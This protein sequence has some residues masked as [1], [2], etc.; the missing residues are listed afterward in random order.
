MRSSRCMLISTISQMSFIMYRPSSFVN[1]RKHYN[2]TWSVLQNEFSST[3]SPR[4]RLGQLTGMRQQWVK[5]EQ[6]EHVCQILWIG[7]YVRRAVPYLLTNSWNILQWSDEWGGMA[8]VIKCIVPS[9]WSL[10]LFTS[11]VY[12]TSGCV[13]ALF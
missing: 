4:T 12:L 6:L 7:S 8:K 5:T 11:I 10:Y 13:C 1:S 9:A 2:L 3:V